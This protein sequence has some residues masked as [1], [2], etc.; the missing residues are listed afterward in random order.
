M[1]YL[2]NYNLLLKFVEYNLIE[3]LL[4]GL[5]AFYFSSQN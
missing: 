5:F 2:N 3:R 1:L 4:F